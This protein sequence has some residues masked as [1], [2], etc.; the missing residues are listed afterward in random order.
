MVVVVGV[1]AVIGVIAYRRYIATA[2]TSEATQLTTAIRAAQEAHKSESGLYAAVSNDTSSFYPAIAPGSFRTEWGAPCTNCA[3][4]D[5][6]AW[7]KLSIH[8]AGPVMYGYASVAGVGGP[9]LSSTPPPAAAAMAMAS[10]ISDAAAT[11]KAT[12]PYYVTVAWGDSN[13][14]GNPCIVLS[15]S[16]SNQVVVQSEG[17]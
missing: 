10:S 14:D 12:D 9:S 15:Y 2:R 11:L 13:A 1:L 17:E 16:T 4:G 7:R 8:P 6:D 3:G 5:T